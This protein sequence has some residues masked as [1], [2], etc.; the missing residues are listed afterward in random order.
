MAFATSQIK[1]ESIGS[2]WLTTGK[3]TGAVGDAA[4]TITVRGQ[5]VLSADFYH[6]KATGGP[7]NK[8]EVSWTASAGIATVTV[9]NYAT[10]TAGRFSIISR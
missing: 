1:T 6:N 10:V 4:G 3:W 8:P 5:E 7:V 9:A 2:S